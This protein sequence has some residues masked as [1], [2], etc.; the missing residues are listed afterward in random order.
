MLLPTKLRLGG[1]S[2]AY[3]VDDVENLADEHRHRNVV[4]R[5]LSIIAENGLD[6]REE[7]IDKLIEGLSVLFDLKFKSLD[8][9]LERTES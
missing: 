8:D 9:R 6:H 1:K 4:G 2:V 3:M 5:L 7:H